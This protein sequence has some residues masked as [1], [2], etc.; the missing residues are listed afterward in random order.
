MRIL[1]FNEITPYPLVW[2]AYRDRCPAPN[3][4][5]A[6]FRIKPASSLKS[7]ELELTRWEFQSV[8]SMNIL[9]E[10]VEGSVDDPGVAVWLDLGGEDGV[11]AP[12]GFGCDNFCEVWGNVRAI[13]VAMEHLRKVEEYGVY[14]MS[15]AVQGARALPYYGPSSENAVLCPGAA[16]PVRKGLRPRLTKLMTLFLR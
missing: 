13:S 12:I 16:N 10:N 5:K 8:I 11:D 7:L 14:T 3:R 9:P 2:P 15:Q 6:H 4:K 1:R